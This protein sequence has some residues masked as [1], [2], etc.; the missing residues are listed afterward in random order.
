MKAVL[1]ALVVLLAAAAPARASDPRLD[2][3]AAKVDSLWA[4]LPERADFAGDEARWK[5]RVV[6]MCPEAEINCALAQYESWASFLEGAYPREVGGASVRARTE[7]R[8]DAASGYTIDLAYPEFAD[9]RFAALN[10]FVADDAHGRADTLAAEWRGNAA[11]A[12]AFSQSETQQRFEVPLVTDHL[13]TVDFEDFRYDSGA[14]HGLPSSWSVLFDLERGR[15]LN[16]DDLFRNDGWVK[17][18]ADLAE[19]ALRERLGGGFQGDRDAVHDVVV[20]IENWSFRKGEAV[21]TFPVYTVAS[22]ADGPQK[23][24]VPYERLTAS[25]RAD[26]A[27]PP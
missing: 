1:T 26:A 15:P 12:R 5:R 4:G 25:L 24:T 22:Y 17:I 3:A 18:A 9:T 23:V 8:W 6:G 16:A 13:V 19:T 20:G 10:E 27:L 21:I 11:D 14:A 7:M 2:A